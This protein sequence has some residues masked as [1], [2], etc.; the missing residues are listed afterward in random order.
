MLQLGLWNNSVHYQWGADN[1][2]QVQLDEV[3][4]H[5]LLKPLSLYFEAKD[6]DQK[7]ASSKQKE[8][9]DQIHHKS[10]RLQVAC[11]SKDNITRNV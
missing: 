3:G 10:D 1:L 6:D 11:D 8:A 7:G 5:L 4:I 2:A 9:D